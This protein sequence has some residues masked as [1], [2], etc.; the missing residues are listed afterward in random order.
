MELLFQERNGFIKEMKIAPSLS[1]MCK[2]DYFHGMEKAFNDAFSQYARREKKKYAE[3]K[4]ELIKGVADRLYT[5]FSTYGADFDECFTDCIKLS[6]G[7]L[8]N[9]RWGIAQK[10]VNMSFKYLY[11]YDG[12]TEIEDKFEKC[13]MP[14]DKY[15]IKWVRSLKNKDINERLNKIN[16]AWTNLDEVLYNDVQKLIESTLSKGAEYRI[17]YDKRAENGGI[18]ILPQNKLYAEFIIWHQ[19]KINETYNVLRRAESDFQRLGIKWL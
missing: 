17:S 8:D 13:H 11:C 10:F 9:G 16:D 7:I 15:T 4:R 2:D 3:D 1:I 12:A 19:E 18:C 14:L 5:Y 6:K